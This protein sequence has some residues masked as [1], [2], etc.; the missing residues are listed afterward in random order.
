M[1]IPLDPTHRPLFDAVSFAARAHDGQ[2]RKD[3]ATPYAAHPFRVCLVVRDLFG[4]DDPRML[5]TALLHDTL[6][7]TT[8]DFDDI[9]NRFGAEIAT[10][11]A[12]LSKDKCLPESERERVYIEKLKKAPWQ[13]QVCKLADVF[14]NASDVLQMPAERRAHAFQRYEQ[15][16]AELRDIAAPEAKTPI[17]LVH[18]LLDEMRGKISPLS[19]P[20]E[21]GRG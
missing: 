15:Y 2:Y 17:A 8:T 13:V 11:V 16:F 6:E 18:A 14:D 3:G 4:F 10:W 19:P 20:G 9:E 21:G 7:D 5:M 1:T 12:Y